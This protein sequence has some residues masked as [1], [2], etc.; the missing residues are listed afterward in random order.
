MVKVVN[1]FR[2]VV[3]FFRLVVKNGYFGG[4]KSLKIAKHQLFLI[5]RISIEVIDKPKSK[6][7]LFPLYFVVFG[8]LM[9]IVTTF[10]SNLSE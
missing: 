7:L 5:R 3:N 2:S 8:P 1:F 9:N 10:Y 6:H 4:K